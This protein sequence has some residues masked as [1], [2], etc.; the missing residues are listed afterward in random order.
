MF[1]TLYQLRL[2][3]GICSTRN[4]QSDGKFALLFRQC[5][6]IAEEERRRG[7]VSRGMEGK[8]LP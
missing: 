7:N 1:C 2:V 6:P 8:K 5:Q 4:M 3:A